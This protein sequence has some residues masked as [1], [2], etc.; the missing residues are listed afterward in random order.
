MIKILKL[1]LLILLEYQNN[2]NNFP[3]GYTSNWSKEVFV[4]KLKILFRGDMLLLIL[5]EKKL[6]KRFTKTNCKS[7]SKRG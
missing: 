7:K 1:K 2:K 5:V 6:L 3:E 4:K